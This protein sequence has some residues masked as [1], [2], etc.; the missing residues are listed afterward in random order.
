MSLSPAV[1]AHI[2]RYPPPLPCCPCWQCVARPCHHPR[3]PALP[4]SP[5]SSPCPAS[6][7]CPPPP[8]PPRVSADECT[9]MMATPPLRRAMRSLSFSFS[10]SCSVSATRF[11]ICFTRVS[12]SPWWHQQQQHSREVGRDD[13]QHQRVSSHCRGNWNM[14][15]C[16]ALQLSQLRTRLNCLEAHIHTDRAH[17]QGPKQSMQARCVL[18]RTGQEYE[19]VCTQRVCMC[20]CF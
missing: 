17:R 20:L 12:T 4:P 9:W 11:L 14:W 1:A 2:A 19:Q 3:P 6:L 13:T 7:P 8:T 16:A 18:Q 10:Y 5:P 15:T